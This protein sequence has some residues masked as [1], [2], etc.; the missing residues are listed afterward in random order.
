VTLGTGGRGVVGGAG[1]ASGI[2][3][4]G[5]TATAGGDGLSLTGGGGAVESSVFSG[6]EGGFIVEFR[7]KKCTD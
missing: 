3:A 7:T 5:S 1:A 2:G 4:A 6:L